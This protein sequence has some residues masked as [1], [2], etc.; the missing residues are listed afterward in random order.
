MSHS[1]RA[2]FSGWVCSKVNSA[3][4]W[5]LWLGFLFSSLSSLNQCLRIAANRRSP[6]LNGK[7]RSLQ[8]D[9]PFPF[10]FYSVWHIQTNHHCSDQ[11]RTHHLKVSHHMCTI[12]G[13]SSRQTCHFLEFRSFWQWRLTWNADRYNMCLFCH[14]LGTTNPFY[15]V[16]VLRFR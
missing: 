16:L 10:L 6:S 7:R 1:L 13:G 8:W 5:W 9:G 2:V 11:G 14:S 15:F 12:L 4:K 3:G